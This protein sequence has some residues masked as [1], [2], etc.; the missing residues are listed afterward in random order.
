MNKD[1]W[2]TVYC[3]GNLDDSVI[4]KMIDDSYEIVYKKL[5]KK[6]KAELENGI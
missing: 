4:Q 5:T 1:H 3:D 6:V 2:N